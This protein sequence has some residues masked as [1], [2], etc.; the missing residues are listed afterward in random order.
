MLREAADEAVACLRQAEAIA[1]TAEGAN[2]L[3]VALARVGDRRGAAAA[4]ASAAER[5]PGYVDAEMNGAAELPDRITT[6]PLRR[7]ASR[8]EYPRS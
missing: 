7:A 3:G 6:H 8:S 1:H 2:N 5:Y 4:F